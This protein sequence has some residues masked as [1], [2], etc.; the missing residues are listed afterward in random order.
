MTLPECLSLASNACKVLF[1]FVCHYGPAAVAFWQ[2]TETCS[3][4]MQ[5]RAVL[6]L[7]LLLLPPFSIRG[8][9]SGQHGNRKGHRSTPECRR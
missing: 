6:L 3:K 2:W 1:S 9:R 5:G 7:L 8:P 4:V